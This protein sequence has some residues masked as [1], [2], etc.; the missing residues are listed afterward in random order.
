MT[1][2]ACVDHA[3][4]VV[5]PSLAPGL[6]VAAAACY[7]ASA[8]L[9]TADAPGRRWPRLAAQATLLLGVALVT[10]ALGR[11]TLADGHL[12]VTDA[13]GACATLIWAASC[14]YLVLHRSARFPALAPVLLAVVLLLFGGAGV[15]ALRGAPGAPELPGWLVVG[16]VCAALAAYVAFLLAFAGGVGY[17]VQERQLRAASAGSLAGRLPPLLTL[18]RLTL[19]SLLTGFPLLTVALLVGFQGARA[20]EWG[21]LLRDPTVAASLCLWV[22]YAVVLAL[23]VTARLR[24]RKIAWLTVAGFAAVLVAFLGTSL[25][26]PGNHPAAVREPGAGR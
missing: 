12:P 17:L 2:A 7:A 21:A 23:R 20:A 10:V 3:V 25:L 8:A 6:L 18:D 1:P 14:V 11:A 9:A 13:A 15:V 22:F 4:L 24:G 16:H 26:G 5:G 19:A